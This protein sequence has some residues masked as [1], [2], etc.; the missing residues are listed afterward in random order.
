MCHKSLELVDPPVLI[1]R[2]HKLVGPSD[3][4]LS[5]GQLFV[6]KS[7]L[8]AKKLAIILTTVS[9]VFFAVVL[10]ISLTG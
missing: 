10:L 9:V 6:S 7:L 1:R 3:F 2:N 8:K 5:V 4:L